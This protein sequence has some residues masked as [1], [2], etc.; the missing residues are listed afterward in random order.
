MK[1]Y[2]DFAI[3]FLLSLVIFT[4]CSVAA[5]AVNTQ[6]I[7]IVYN[8]GIIASQMS[9]GV[10]VG[11]GEYVLTNKS[12]VY[13]KTNEIKTGPITKIYGH[14]NKYP[15]FLSNETGDI[16]ECKTVAVLDD[17]DLALLKL[18]VKMK[19]TNHIE[20]NLSK[21]PKGTFEVNPKGK[22]FSSTYYGLDR[23]DETGDFFISKFESK[24]G[25]YEKNAVSN[26]I[27][28]CDIPFNQYLLPGGILLYNDKFYGILNIMVPLTEITSGK[29]IQ[30]LG[31]KYSPAFDVIEYCKDHDIYFNNSETKKGKSEEKM[32]LL[33]TVN[34]IIGSLKLSKPEKTI[35][36]IE[37]YP[38]K[39]TS[40]YI[41]VLK[42]MAYE[43]LDKI[44]EAK[45]TYE[46]AIELAP[47]EPYAQIRLANLKSDKITLLNEL[48]EKYR[49][50]SRIY[51]RLARS[52]AEVKNY[53]LARSFMS[54][55][56][57]FSENDFEMI[58]EK[59]KYEGE[60]KN[61]QGVFDC[62]K[63]L[64]TIYPYFTDTVI[65]ATKYC[66]D[67]GFFDV[68]LPYC[69][70]W[71]SAE[72]DSYEPKAYKVKILFELGEDEEAVAL[73][74]DIKD[75]PEDKETK[76]IIKDIEDKYL[77]EY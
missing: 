66:V 9:D 45:E 75:K 58:L 1:K 49:D 43:S 55:A 36:L 2:L 69:N 11:D 64:K 61:P 60:L 52:Y 70:D 16:Y 6:S 38:L 15:L 21:I 17:C 29:E 35:E 22:K 71:I 67:N 41:N 27:Y 59:A 50:D 33:N 37:E 44:D 46:K 18:P 3:C 63:Q 19:Y 51:D 62:L 39:E 12:A 26:K 24:M 8:L 14:V 32:S 65:L 30:Y 57:M 13:E 53:E 10:V 54:K 40:Y 47:D 28:M 23:N 5:F 48:S 56:I 42:G 34:A 72:P 77:K 73:Y 74:E 76:K 20:E 68:A 25:E 7:G 4:L 31:A